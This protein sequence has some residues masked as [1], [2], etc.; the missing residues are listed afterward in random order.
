MEPLRAGLY[1]R[2]RLEDA[3][4]LAMQGHALASLAEQRGWRVVR[5]E[6]ETAGET[7]RKLPALERVLAAAN[8]GELDV[9]VAWKLDRIA[10]SLPELVSVLDGL[11]AGGVSVATLADDF[12]FTGERGPELMRILRTLAAFER[13]THRDRVRSGLA[14]TGQT[15]GRPASARQ[16]LP[17]ARRLAAQ[18]HS[19]REIARRL[20]IHPKTVARLLAEKAR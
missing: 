9:V 14:R 18:G 20:G 7:V 8:A 10:R 4:D 19:Q 16:H 15:V 5:T 13:V 17:E 6:H 3:L 2:I 12:D 11:A 1:A